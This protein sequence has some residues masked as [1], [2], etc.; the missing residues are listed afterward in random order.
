MSEIKQQGL[1]ELVKSQ[2]WE[3]VIQRCKV[4]TKREF[5]AQDKT[6]FLQTPLHLALRL[7]APIR[8]IRAFTRHNQFSKAMEMRDTYCGYLPLHS[9]VRYCS[10]DS[11]SILLFLSISNQLNVSFLLEQHDRNGM[12]PLHIAC[13]FGSSLEII[14]ALV[15]ANPIT[16]SIKTTKGKS[17]LFLASECSKIAAKSISFIISHSCLNNRG[18]DDYRGYTPLHMA[19][20]NERSVEI[21]SLLAQ[22]DP[23]ACFQKTP[24]SEQTPLG[25]YFGIGNSSKEIVR[26]LLGQLNGDDIGVVHLILIFPQNV[27]ALLEFVLQTFPADVE[28]L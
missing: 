13:S 16:T 24:S 20:I 2:Q 7:K 14:E 26:L 3:Q 21:V 17:V 10:T 27:P 25:F 18:H 15:R 23:S 5:L 1:L 12:I 11:A 4:A 22:Y 9:A 28:K 8:V 6:S 19:C